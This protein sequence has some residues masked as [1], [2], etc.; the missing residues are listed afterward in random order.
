MTQSSKE[1]SKD[2]LVLKFLTSAEPGTSIWLR[3]HQNA[4]HHWNDH[5]DPYQQQRKQP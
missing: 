4:Y 2:N 1:N 3:H 5:H